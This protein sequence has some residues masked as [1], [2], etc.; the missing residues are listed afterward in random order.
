M[1]FLGTEGTHSH[2]PTVP[3]AAGVDALSSQ[4]SKLTARGRAPRS[5]GLLASA[6][7]LEIL[8]ESS[9]VLGGKRNKRQV[10]WRENSKHPSEENE[11][12]TSAGLGMVKIFYK[13][14]QNI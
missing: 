7:A 11:L 10:I 4:D 1:G 13:L 5:A 9:L 14:R 6:E 8:A 12:K 3:S 2:L